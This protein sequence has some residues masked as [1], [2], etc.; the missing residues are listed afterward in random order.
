MRDMRT[1]RRRLFE[2]GFLALALI[3]G[4]CGGDD[5]PVRSDAQPSASTTVV[6]APARPTFAAGTTMAAIQAK[7]KLVVGTR[8]DLTGFGVRNSAT[9]AMEGF[10]VEVAKL[11]AVGIFGGTPTDVIA[12][13]DFVDSVMG[14]REA[15]IKDGQVDFA[16]A[17]YRITDAAKQQVDFAGPYF[18]AGQDLLVRS[19]DT[20]I[21]GF[22]DLSGKKVCSSRATGT[23]VANV[24]AKAPD[25][26]SIQMDTTP[27][28]ADALTAGQVD[29]VASVNTSLLGPLEKSAGALRL[30]GN[31]S[32][33]EPSG[34]G[35]KRGDDAFRTFIN[36]RLEKLYAG[37][38]WASAYAATLG[39]FG[40][41]TPT[42]PPVDRYATA[43]A[44]AATS[45]SR[46]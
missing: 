45:T 24:R 38:Q 37:G 10:D 27:Q 1:Q 44:A 41:K 30:V 14:T 11:I 17:A 3:T 39:K 21:K 4:A 7:G 2:G 31:P 18:M 22:S 35:V 25:A 29:A 8:L 43:A 12:K 33:E 42:P 26:E 36:D 23:A 9:G 15:S 13:I 46:P 6:T 28:C 40:W 5:T 34:I 16:I 19:A 32:T 20:T